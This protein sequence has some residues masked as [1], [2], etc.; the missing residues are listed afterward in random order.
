[1]HCQKS[2]L[3]ATHWPFQVSIIRNVPDH[4]FS[5][6]QSTFPFLFLYNGK[7]FRSDNLRVTTEWIVLRQT[8][9]MVCH[10]NKFLCR[11][12]VF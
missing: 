2:L 7:Q 1:M 12:D 5:F 9:R 3:K 11:M 10:S 4:L 6:P 8:L